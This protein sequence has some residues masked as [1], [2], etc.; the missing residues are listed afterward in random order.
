MGDVGGYLRPRMQEARSALDV[1]L[2]VLCS[3]QSKQ[4]PLRSPLITSREP[5]HFSVR[6]EASVARALGGAS[7]R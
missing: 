6:C 5:H 7:S 3:S 4:S 1:L 2:E